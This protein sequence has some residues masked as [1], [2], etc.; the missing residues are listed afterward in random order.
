[1]GSPDN[2]GR[3]FD[4][5]TGGPGA[6]AF[7]KALAFGG[8]DAQLAG[9]QKGT[10][11]AKP[12]PT[13][14]KAPQD[15][16]F[17]FLFYVRNRYAISQEV[18]S[19]VSM[20]L[21]GGSFFFSI[22]EKIP[23]KSRPSHVGDGQRDIRSNGLSDKFK[24]STITTD[25]QITVDLYPPIRAPKTL[26]KKISEKITSAEFKQGFKLD[27]SGGSFNAEECPGGLFLVT[28]ELG[29]IEK[30]IF[31]KSG[32]TL[33]AELADRGLASED[34][35]YISPGTAVNAGTEYTVAYWDDRLTLTCS[36]HMP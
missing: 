4:R 27:A 19:A 12:A 1:M 10:A 3:V 30:P 14:Q 18:A 29:L 20:D 36:V 25:F 2:E 15:R 5:M 31:V 9:G 32:K 13:K 33:E 11:P 8:I 34:F 17:Q 26:R 16:C 28:G 24:K 21:G 35:A 23:K 6:S 22:D 7:E